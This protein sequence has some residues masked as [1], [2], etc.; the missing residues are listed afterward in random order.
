[1]ENLITNGNIKDYFDIYFMDISDNRNSE[2]IGK[3]D[4]INIYMAFKHIGKFILSILFYN[5]AIVYFNISQG[6]WGYMRDLGFLIP[7]IFLRKKVVLHLRGSEFREFYLGMS[8][9][10]KGLTK[11]TF[12]RVSRIIVLGNKIKTIF[13]DLIEIDN[14]R[15][16]PN[17]IDYEQFDLDHGNEL[18]LTDKC[19]KI[20]FLSSLRK[21][22]G[23]FEF[24]QSIPFIL[25][26]HPEAK[27]TIAGEWRSDNERLDAEHF[28]SKNHLS[29]SVKFIGQ[30][31]GTEKIRLYLSHDIFVFTPVQPEGLPWVILE[32]MSASIPVVYTDQGVISEVAVNSETGLVVDPNPED[33]CKKVCFL[34]E[35]P[36]IAKEMGKNGRK[37][38]ENMFSEKQYFHGLIET[39]KEVANS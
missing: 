11:F 14:I 25:K 27:I 13:N 19:S 39:L 22:K 3:L 18:R 1:M 38:V 29:D 33:I 8:P 37:R 2:N 31:T 5:P 4:L 12:K 30:V 21:R 15:V 32:A 10:L 35:N 17:G 9:I 36:K 20:L 26:R 34:I 23:I 24:L 7:S 6:I 28:I 16:V